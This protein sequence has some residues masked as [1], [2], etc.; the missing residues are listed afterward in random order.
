MEPFRIHINFINQSDFHSWLPLS[1]SHLNVKDGNPVL[2][3]NWIL[4][5]IQYHMKMNRVSM[6]FSIS[7]L[8]QPI[9]R[10]FILNAANLA[11]YQRILKIDFMRS[12]EFYRMQAA[13]HISIDWVKWTSNRSFALPQHTDGWTTYSHAHPP[14]PPLVYEFSQNDFYW[15]I[16]L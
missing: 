13:H 14:S 7:T 11:C 4:G 1:S 5:Y 16:I 6:V 10:T 9:A 8:C 15:F 3:V 12:S 2:L